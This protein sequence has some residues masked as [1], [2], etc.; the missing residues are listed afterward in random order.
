MEKTKK[1]VNV[2]SICFTGLMAA[3][4]FVFTYTFKITFPSGYTHLGDC[5]IFLSLVILGRK[6]A[7]LAAGVGACLADLIGGYSQWILPSF[8][9]KYVMVLICGLIMEYV[10]KNSK[11]LG[12]LAGG[13]LGGAFQVFAYTAVKVV[14]IDKAYAFSSLPRLVFQTVFGLVAALVIVLVLDKSKL[15]AK[16]NKMADTGE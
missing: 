15:L 8:I 10:I 16:L 4:V 1:N 7:S 3:L 12:L 11:F 5:M 2:R 14:L 9:I 13:I 6:R